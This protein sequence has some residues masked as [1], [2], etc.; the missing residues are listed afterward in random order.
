MVA[1]QFLLF[2]L[3][4]INVAT[5][6]LFGIDKWKA[7]RS[8]WRIAEATLLG[9]AVMC[10]SLGAWSGMRI[11]HHKTRHKKFKYGIPFILLIQIAIVLTM[12]H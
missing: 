11:W 9:L 7:K 3:T 6:F 1:T 2:Y 5:F 8:Q 10:G 12:V 4:T